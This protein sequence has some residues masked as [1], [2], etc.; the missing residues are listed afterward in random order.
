MRGVQNF[1]IYE[2]RVRLL[3]RKKTKY[4]FSTTLLCKILHQKNAA[5]K[6][7]ETTQKLKLEPDPFNTEEIRIQIPE[8]GK[9]KP[10]SEKNAYSGT[11]RVERIQIYIST[12]YSPGI[13]TFK[14]VEDE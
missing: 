3:I 1:H 10:S 13:I 14:N 7:N 11:R 6:M 5:V 12:N 2:T 8:K 9:I 4:D